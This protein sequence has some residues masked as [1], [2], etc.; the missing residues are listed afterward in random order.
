MT[1]NYS[2]SSDYILVEAIKEFD[3]TGR[4]GLREDMIIHPIYTIHS[5]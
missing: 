4:H 1:D 2:G 5:V 3:N